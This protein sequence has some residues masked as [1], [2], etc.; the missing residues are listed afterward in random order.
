MPLAWT[1][2]TT[3]TVPTAWNRTIQQH[4]L[5]WLFSLSGTCLNKFAPQT[6]DNETKQEKC[7]PGYFKYLLFLPVES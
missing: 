5:Y 2:P 3:G 7:W 1:I 4:L 6:T